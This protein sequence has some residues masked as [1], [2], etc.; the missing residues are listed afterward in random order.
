MNTHLPSSNTIITYKLSQTSGL[1]SLKNSTGLLPLRCRFRVLQLESGKEFW[2]N[3]KGGL[4]SINRCSHCGVVINKGSIAHR[5]S[6]LNG[7]RV[8]HNL[9]CQVRIDNENN[10]NPMKNRK[11]KRKDSRPNNKYR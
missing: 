5:L 6:F 10:E 7:K 4:Q 2:L 8:P 9:I 1:L 11:R 3:G